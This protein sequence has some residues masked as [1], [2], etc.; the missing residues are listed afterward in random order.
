MLKI[1]ENM[2]NVTICY[3]TV[4]GYILNDT[5]VTL[6]YELFENVKYKSFKVLSESELK[7]IRKWRSKS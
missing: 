7:K 6:L 4:P 3:G 5:K 2:P 1:T